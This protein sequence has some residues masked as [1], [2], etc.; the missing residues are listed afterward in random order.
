MSF[1]R[2]TKRSDGTL[3]IEAGEALLQVKHAH[4]RLFFTKCSEMPLPASHLVHVIQV[5]SKLE[6]GGDTGD[7]AFRTGTSK[8]GA[9][10]GEETV[11]VGSNKAIENR[12]TINLMLM[13]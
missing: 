1:R 6:M 12:A 11:F 7:V 2:T 13:Q 9:A 5:M 8:A 3:E 10:V 4:T